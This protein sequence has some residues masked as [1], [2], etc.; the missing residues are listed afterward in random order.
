MLDRLVP[1]PLPGYEEVHKTLMGHGH[2]KLARALFK[3]VKLSG[4]GAFASAEEQAPVVSTAKGDTAVQ[5][6]A[7]GRWKLAE[8][9][10]GASRQVNLFQ[11]RA[12]GYGGGHGHGHGHGEEGGHGDHGGHGHGGH[13]GHDARHAVM[14][15]AQ[16]V[17]QAS[18]SIPQDGL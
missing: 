18:C 17:V 8:I 1:A 5:T 13:G 4:E 3:D 16:M 11:L 9:H 2:G 6:L 10:K 12:G 15:G 14:H 7:P